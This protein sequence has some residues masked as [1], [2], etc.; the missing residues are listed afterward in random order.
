MSYKEVLKWRV[1]GHSADFSAET[2]NSV[3]SVN[4]E[5]GWKARY[6]VPLGFMKFLGQRVERSRKRQCCVH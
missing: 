6:I 5:N 2:L 3:Y 1:A 4:F